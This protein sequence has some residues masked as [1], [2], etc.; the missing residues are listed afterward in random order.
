MRRVALPVL[1]LVLDADG[2]ELAHAG[3]V[4]SDLMACVH[5]ALVQLRL[6]PRQR[7]P[8]PA[9]PLQDLHQT[10]ETYLETLRFPFELPHFH[11]IPRDF[12][13]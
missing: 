5:E 7:Q 13:R 8:S 3:A 4:E 2:K 1:V 11:V 12:V 9:H 10:M 6:Q